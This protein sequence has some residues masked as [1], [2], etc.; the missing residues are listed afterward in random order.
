MT[1]RL[2]ARLDAR[3]L[4]YL[5]WLIRLDPATLDPVLD[6]F[7]M[8]VAL[9]RA[10]QWAGRLWRERDGWSPPAVASQVVAQFEEAPQAALAGLW[11]ALGDGDRSR[12]NIDRYLESYRFVHPIIT[13]ED[14]IALGLPPGP[15]FARLLG[16]LRQAWLDGS[17]SDAASERQLLES[18]VDRARG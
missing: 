2:D 15:A 4:M 3:D 13:G 5:L 14:L 11:L 17:I 16:T 6:R 12:A 7:H 18:L 8:P 9:S 1:W 10:V